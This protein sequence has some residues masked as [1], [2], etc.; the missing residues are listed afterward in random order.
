[1][2]IDEEERRRQIDASNSNVP[3]SPKVEVP[4]LQPAVREDP[5]AVRFLVREIRF[6]ASEIF[7]AEVED[8]ARPYEGREQT[9]SALQGLAAAINEAYRKR[10]VV[11]A[12][13]LIP[14]QNVSPRGGRDPS[15]RRSAGQHPAAK[16]IPRRPATTSRTASA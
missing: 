3:R 11:T 15:G 4:P 10:G 2:R 9:L 1:M 13:A 6:S 16:A 12:Q 5:N 8:F 7:S 14:P